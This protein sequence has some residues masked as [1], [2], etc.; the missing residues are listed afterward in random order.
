MIRLLSTATG[1]SS[2]STTPDASSG[3]EGGGGKSRLR[4]GLDWFQSQLLS[5]DGMALPTFERRR[6]R[7]A[8]QWN[9]S[10]TGILRIKINLDKNTTQSVI[11]LGE[12]SDEEYHDTFFDG[13]D[14]KRIFE[15][16]YH[17]V[18]KLQAGEI[19]PKV[20]C[21]RG[22]DKLYGERQEACRTIRSKSINAVMDLQEEQWNNESDDAE[23]LAK[24]CR[25]ITKEAKRRAVSEA[26]QDTRA[27]QSY[28]R[29]VDTSQ[30]DDTSTSST[31]TKTKSILKVR[32]SN[33][34]L[35]IGQP[36]F[37]D[38]RKPTASFHELRRPPFANSTTPLGRA[39]RETRRVFPSSPNTPMQRS[40]ERLAKQPIGD[41]SQSRRQAIANAIDQ[42][43]DVA[44]GKDTNG[45]LA[46][47][48][49]SQASFAVDDDHHQL[50]RSRVIRRSSSA[51]ALAMKANML[52]QQRNSLSANNDNDDEGGGKGKQAKDLEKKRAP[53]SRSVS[54]GANNLSTMTP[55][56]HRRRMG[57]LL[58]TTKGE[59]PSGAETPT[60]KKRAPPS[61]SKSDVVTGLGLLGSPLLQRRTVPESSKESKSE[62]K[63]RAPP[64]KSKSGIVAGAKISRLARPTTPVGGNDNGS[65]AGNSSKGTLKKHSPISLSEH[66]RKIDSSEEIHSIDGYSMD[67]KLA[68]KKHLPRRTA[69]D[70]HRRGVGGADDDNSMAKV[71]IKLNQE[72][73][74]KTLPSRRLSADQ[75]TKGNAASAVREL[76]LESSRSTNGKVVQKKVPGTKSI[77][78]H[79]PR[80]RLS[81]HERGT[82]ETERT[83]KVKSTPK[84][85][86]SGRSTSDH[87]RKDVPSDDDEIL[88]LDA[89]SQEEKI[90]KKKALPRRSITDLNRSKHLSFDDDELSEDPKSS[91]GIDVKRMPPQRSASSTSVPSNKSSNARAPARERPE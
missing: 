73:T 57:V 30:W 42:A 75:G 36:L 10:D 11:G 50:P 21:T 69:S 5:A 34:G 29:D 35:P 2:S 47:S 25:E 32:T 65:V 16:A 18:E 84:R 72:I 19:D 48:N 79:G 85:T 71:K 27:A 77:S 54:S 62:S 23:E 22:L 81:D 56:S 66:H 38:L 24:V 39:N 43:S 91:K 13:E 74:Q 51:G 33:S 87:L 3:M 82:S 58:P 15:Q 49:H 20:I 89:S 8:S 61:R 14:L 88:S 4:M 31:M 6:Q 86:I 45:I 64:Q 55:S 53:P 76:Y 67:A 83:S 80:K 26:R 60:V 90:V 9:R 68:K 63:T 70:L 41:T 7:R 59:P 40:K 17:V 37:P 44:F 12:Y 78:E 52:P 46:D 28:L 1:T